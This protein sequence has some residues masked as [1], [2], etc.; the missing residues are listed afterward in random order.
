MQRISFVAEEQGFEPWSQVSPA[1]RLAGGRTRPLCDSSVFTC[2]PP[3]RADL[4]LLVL[5]LDAAPGGGRGIRT[6]GAQ[7][8]AVFK[9]AAINRSAIPPP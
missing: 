7:H 6:P 1:N 8:P 9:T 3:I 4:R 5:G 2:G